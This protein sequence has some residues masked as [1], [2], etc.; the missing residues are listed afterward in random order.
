MLLKVEYFQCLQV[1]RQKNQ[2]NKNDQENQ[3][4]ETIMK[5]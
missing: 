4:N 1:I 5:E 3:K 2:G